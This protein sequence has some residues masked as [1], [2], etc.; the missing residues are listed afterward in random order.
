MPREAPQ[1]EAAWQTPQGSSSDHADEFSRLYAEHFDFVWRT[2]RYLGEPEASLDDAAQDVF[3]VAYRRL[4]DFEARASTRSWLFAITMRVT[5]DHRRS[6]RRKRRLLDGIKGVLPK[7]VVTPYEQT[8]HK[9]QG[10]S[11]MLALSMLSESHRVTFVMSDL[12]GMTAPEIATTLGVNMNTVYSR[13]RVSR[14]VVKRA[15]EQA[16]QEAED[17]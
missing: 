13:L 15:L 5:S 3:L 6:R 12:E 7:S 17:A 2:A 1:T 8:A 14:I 11:L 10:H 9:E 16:K 4:Q